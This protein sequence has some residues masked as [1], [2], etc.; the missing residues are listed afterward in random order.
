MDLG[1]L[2]K[3]R[4]V[5]TC[6]I[7]NSPTVYRPNLWVFGDSPYKFHDA[8]WR[9]PAVL[10]FVPLS[11]MDC[12][13]LRTKLSQ[14][15]FAWMRD[16][17]GRQLFPR[18]MPGVLGYRRSG[19]LSVE[20]FLSEDSVSFGRSEK[21]A[22]REKTWHIN[23]TFFSLIKIL[24]CVGV[25]TIY[26]LGCD[27]SMNADQ[28]YAFDQDKSRGGVRSNNRA[29][30]RMNQ[31]FA[32]A[33]PTFEAAGLFVYNCTPNSGLTAFD[34]VDYHAAVRGVRCPQ[35]PL[36]SVGWYALE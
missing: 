14:N 16:Q 21:W 29:Y 6:G 30:A 4:G 26:L 20:H 22:A 17:N 2:A 28:P 35:D 27:F 9:D 7:N 10:K 33:R 8:I 19:R 12:K 36:D 23:N 32:E 11:F 18:D 24:W 15:S 1:L 5:L 3:T 13:P 31:W 25:R 34:Y